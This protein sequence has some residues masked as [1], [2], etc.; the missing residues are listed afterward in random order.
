MPPNNKLLTNTIATKT[1]TYVTHNI[2][3]L[4]GF[5]QISVEML[6]KDFGASKVSRIFTT[7]G[8]EIRAMILCQHYGHRSK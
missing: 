6:Q 3:H 7:F 8:C 4:I 1:V 5:N 2:L